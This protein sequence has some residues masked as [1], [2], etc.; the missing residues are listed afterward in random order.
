MCQ[1]RLLFEGCVDDVISVAGISESDKDDLI[2]QLAFGC[3]R[4]KTP[5]VA[6]RVQAL[7]T[8]PR[9]TQEDNRKSQREYYS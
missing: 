6:E 9:Q 1:V 2:Y 4:P 8:N 7:S 5:E 3:E